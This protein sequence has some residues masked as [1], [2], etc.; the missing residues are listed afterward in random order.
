MIPTQGF[1]GV[2]SHPSERE[3][4]VGTS[5]FSREVVGGRYE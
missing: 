5:T 3:A 2:L 1:L 4:I